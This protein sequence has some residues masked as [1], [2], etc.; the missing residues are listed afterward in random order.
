M[1][2]P[3][4]PGFRDPVHATQTTFRTLL[5]ALAQPGQ[6]EQ[7]TAAITP[8]IGLTVASAATCLTLLDLETWLWI[9]P[10]CDREVLSWLLFHTGCQFTENPRQANF[11]LIWDVQ[12]L[13]D[14]T[15]FNWGTAEYPESSTTLFLQVEAL[16]QGPS[17]VLKGPGI[18]QE[19]TIAPQLPQQFWSQWRLN[20]RSYPLGLD[21]FIFTE[22]R[23]VGLPRTTAIEMESVE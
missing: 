16:S 17:V 20:H 4:L 14:L 13:P 11:A 12:S 22:S 21:A 1:L 9:Q 8:P 7:V 2:I 5:N 6:T 10:E 15:Q 3:S 23:V 18:W 19:R